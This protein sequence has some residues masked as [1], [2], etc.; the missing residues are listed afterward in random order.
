MS[1][2]H[3]L[4][5]EQTADAVIVIDKEGVIRIWNAA[6][7]RLFEFSA[8][9][10]LNQSVDLI[11]PER[12]REAHWRG[13]SHAMA[14]GKTRLGGVPTRTRALCKSGNKLY[15]QMSF[16]VVLD[17]SRQSVAAVAMARRLDG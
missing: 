11:I 13:F 2:L 10:A 7:E 6:A 5:L 4:A 17:E 8:D 16:A 12:L 15:V 3:T 1:D 9:E 14:A